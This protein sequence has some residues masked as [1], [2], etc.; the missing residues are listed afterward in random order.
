MLFYAAA[1]SSP[2]HFLL[3]NL[4][5]C[6]C[7]VNYHYLLTRIL[8]HEKAPGCPRDLE[9]NCSESVVF[10]LQLFSI[11]PLNKFWGV[12]MSDFDFTHLSIHANINDYD[13]DNARLPQG[14]RQPAGEE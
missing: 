5:T 4:V 10:F 13:N 6:L 14:W 2:Q 7:M 11:G 12:A 8:L 1:V 3:K 9:K